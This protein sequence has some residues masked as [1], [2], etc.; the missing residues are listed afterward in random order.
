[1]IAKMLREYLTA[2]DQRY[3]F[4]Q[5]L[6][7]RLTN[8]VFWRNT[9]LLLLAN[10]IVMGLGI[11]RTPLMTW[12]LPKNE[13]GM[14]GVVASWLPFL[15]L[16]SLSGMDGAT[17]HYVSK[18]QPWAF[19]S[20]LFL[21]F[22]WSLLSAAGFLGGAVYWA[23][24]GEIT[25]AWLFV[26]TGISYPLT[27]GMTASA[28]M[29]AAQ[30]RYKGLFWYRIFE[31]L[32]DF[33]GFIPLALTA[34]WISKV[35]TFYA[36]NQVATAIQQTGVSL[37][38]AWQLK[39]L[40]TSR[41]AQADEREFVRYSKHLT[42]I[43]GISV[44]QARTDA[45]LVGAFETLDT[46][47]DY[48]IALLVSEQ[49][50]RLWGIYVSIRYPPLVRMP[51]KRRRQRFVIEGGL[52]TLGFSAIG[53]IV[54]LLAHWLI[55][56]VLPV[57]YVRSLGYMNLLIATSVIGLPGAMAEIYFRTLQDEKRQYLLR[58]VAAFIG[59]TA[60]L[61]LIFRWGAYGAATGRLIANLVFS[62]FGIWLFARHGRL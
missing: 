29:L 13:I 42:A 37:F 49:F 11:I 23:T 59:V 34:F 20:A 19:V 38:L 14:L 51:L 28:G 2:L 62:V 60:P 24:R 56:I 32:T 22:R 53:L 30:E 27:I 10:L 3:H 31:S 33:T 36:T 9:G 12:V 8:R 46:M 35:V 44:L 58:T 54:A 15:Q 55:P 25:L 16:A 5:A 40:G 4:T 48:S 39:K 45:F 26:I 47:A 43:T 18:G 41:P 52:L 61:L 50:K 1:M 21:R 6:K 57:S 17:F 7:R